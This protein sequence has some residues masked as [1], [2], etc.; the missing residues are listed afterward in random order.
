MQMNRKIGLTFATAL[1]AFLRQ[2]PDIILVGEIR[3]QET[4][5]IAVEA[6]LTGHM[7]FSTLHTNDAPSTV[8]R[9]TEMDVEPFMVSA[10]LVC[11]CAQRLMRR[12]CKACKQVYEPTGREAEIIQKAIQWSGPIFRHNPEGC[13]ACS[14]SGYKGRVGI[15]ELL[16]TSEALVEAINK[17]VE[18]AAIKR[19]GMMNGMFTLHQ[20]SMK[21]VKAGLSTMEESIA[22]V[23]PDMEDL[24]AIREEFAIELDVK[25][26][27]EDLRKTKLDEIKRQRNQRN[28]AAAA[29]SDAASRA[30]A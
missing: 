17:E 20:D 4:A 26:E 11:V 18:T 28:A 29:A 10:S 8:A 19:I 25:R 23:P 16:A 3:D 6:A 2:D 12:V 7:L 24:D 27:A 5:G 13:P 1:R 9:L 30:T 22:T 14:R 21:K 15:H